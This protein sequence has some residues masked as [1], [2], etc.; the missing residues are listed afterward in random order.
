MPKIT[1]PVRGRA[2]MKDTF[3]TY[4][5]KVKKFFEHMK[6]VITLPYR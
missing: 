4:L 3:I 2:R 6:N 5:M 1:L